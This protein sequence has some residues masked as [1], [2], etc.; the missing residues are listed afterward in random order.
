MEFNLN[1]DPAFTGRRK[2]QEH[3]RMQ[4]VKMYRQ[5]MSAAD[6]AKLFEVSPRAVF[7]WVTAFINHGQAGL[8][9]RATPGRPPSLRPIS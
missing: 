2:E 1:T 9:A 5:G 4:V 7:Q 3:N 6:I 8:V